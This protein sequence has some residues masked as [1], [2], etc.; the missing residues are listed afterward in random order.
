MKC[1]RDLQQSPRHRKKTE[2]YPKVVYKQGNFSLSW[3]AIFTPS[4][5]FQLLQR[6]ISNIFLRLMTMEGLTEEEAAIYDRQLRV[7]GVEA[8]QRFVSIVSK[9]VC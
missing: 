9:S 3:S 2:F 8:Q 7:W 5:G 1:S 4:C 6:G